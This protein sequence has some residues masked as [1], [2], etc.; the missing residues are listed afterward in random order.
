MTESQVAAVPGPAAN[1]QPALRPIEVKAV[2]RHRD[3][4]RCTNCGM[5]AVEHIERYGRSLDVHR[6]V[7]GSEY[8]VDGSVTLCRP[9]H[10]PRPKRAKNQVNKRTIPLGTRVTPDHWRALRLMVA[11]TRRTDS[12]ELFL[13]LEAWLV[14]HGFWPLPPTRKAKT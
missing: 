6:I 14:Q 12:M 10:G 7:P 11:Q 4:Y 3:G 5:T 8:T 9:C 2:V 13:A 1:A